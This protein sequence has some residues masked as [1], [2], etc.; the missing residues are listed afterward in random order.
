VSFLPYVFC[1]RLR[2][3]FCV[4]K[5]KLHECFIG[6]AV[7]LMIFLVRT[8]GSAITERCHQNGF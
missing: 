3:L 5:F 4:E 8:D 2:A 1:S 6:V 7:I